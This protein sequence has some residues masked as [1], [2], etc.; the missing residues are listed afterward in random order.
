MLVPWIPGVGYYFF[1]THVSAIAPIGISGAAN[2]LVA[3]RPRSIIIAYALLILRI[4]EEYR[5][6]TVPP[7]SVAFW[8]CREHETRNF[9]E[10][11]IPAGNC[12]ICRQCFCNVVV[13]ASFWLMERTRTK[14]RLC[15]Q[16]RHDTSIWGM[17]YV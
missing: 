9:V 4:A 1:L 15:V 6:D 8:A 17:Y 2:A 16:L 11:E 7:T 14:D 3:V 12:Y 13:S 10:E 5:P